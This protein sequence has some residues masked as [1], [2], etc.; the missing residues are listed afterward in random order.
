[1]F[2]NRIL[3]VSGIVLG[4]IV[5]YPKAIGSSEASSESSTSEASFEAQPISKPKPK[6][7]TKKKKAQESTWSKVWNIA[8]KGI[9]FVAI[10]GIGY[11]IA[12]YFLAQ[13][14][15]IPEN[16]QPHKHIYNAFQNASYWLNKKYNP[17]YSSDEVTVAL[18]NL[19]SPYSLTY[20][21][22]KPLLSTIERVKPFQ[23]VHEAETCAYELSTLLKGN[24]SSIRIRFVYDYIQGGIYSSCSDLIQQLRM[25]FLD[26]Y[27]MLVEFLERNKKDI[28]YDY[29]RKTAI[30]YLKTLADKALGSETRKNAAGLVSLAL[31]SSILFP[32]DI[33][34]FAQIIRNSKNLPMDLAKRLENI[35]I[36]AQSARNDLIEGEIKLRMSEIEEQARRDKEEMAQHE[37]ML[38]QNF[39]LVGIL[40]RL[41]TFE[42]DPLMQKHAR[43]IFNEARNLFLEKGEDFFKKYGEQTLIEKAI[44]K[45]YLL[46]NSVLKLYG[47]HKRHLAKDYA[48]EQEKKWIQTFPYLK[49]LYEQSL[50]PQDVLS[51]QKLRYALD[52]LWAKNDIVSD[53]R[54]LSDTS[55]AL[56]EYIIFGGITPKN[57]YDTTYAKMNK[58]YISKTLSIGQ[59]ADEKNQYITPTALQ[60]IKKN[61]LEG[62]G[63]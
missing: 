57:F 63:G 56:T 12:A 18:D 22:L 52:I 29:E 15:L 33:L 26:S 41:A 13:K 53:P 43:K 39:P 32:G 17:L 28:G 44:D 60:K 49:K 42:R 14:G 38:I 55:G 2:A 35:E 21:L 50:L 37:K 59:R 34:D 36:L 31:L 10:A 7:K 8:K 16:Y 23:S 47:A 61:A 6:P 40:H 24:G 30:G 11:T 25:K 51:E 62:R 58:E 27:E 48:S 1:M 4:C 9:G 45:D 20:S 5:T 3:L 54:L 46:R 19:Y